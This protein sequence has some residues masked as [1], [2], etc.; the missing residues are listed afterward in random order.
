MTNNLNLL[1]PQGHQPMMSLREEIGQIWSMLATL[2]G[3]MA[4]SLGLMQK[5]AGEN[6]RILAKIEDRFAG[7][8]DF[9]VNRAKEAFIQE[10]SGKERTRQENQEKAD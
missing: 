8:L 2:K 10:A 3:E 6:K 7:F 1:G 4:Q 5:S 9:A